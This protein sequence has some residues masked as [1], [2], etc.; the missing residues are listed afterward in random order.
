MLLTR[1]GDGSK[2]VAMGDPNQSDLKEKNG[3][4]D[5]TQRFQSNT[6]NNQTQTDNIRYIELGNGD[7]QRS[8]LVKQILELYS[9]PTQTIPPVPVTTV[10]KLYKPL[11]PN[12]DPYNPL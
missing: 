9:K 7:I 11:P 10:S 4:V 2:I 5:F 8:E 12:Y 3:L 1:C 6:P